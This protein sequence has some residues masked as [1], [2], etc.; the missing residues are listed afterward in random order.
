MDSPC[1]LY[2]IPG[3]IYERGEKLSRSIIEMTCVYRSGRVSF[4]ANLAPEMENMSSSESVSTASE[5]RAASVAT[6]ASSE[7][8]ANTSLASI[9]SFTGDPNFMTSLAR[10]LTVIQ[11]FTQKKRQLTISQ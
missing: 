5:R 4:R 6:A 3:R 2:G 11:A 1:R 8:T 7:E 9:N 10:G